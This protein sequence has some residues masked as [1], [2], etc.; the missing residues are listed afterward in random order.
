MSS[1]FQTV[2]A[3]RHAHSKPHATYFIIDIA[4]H[5]G[6]CTHLEHEQHAEL[7]FA[8]SNLV[9]LQIF[10]TYMRYMWCDRLLSVL[11]Y[12]NCILFKVRN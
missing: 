5:S 6:N 7:H 12:I 3:L 8:L 2:S 1:C 4:H 11:Y 10:G 9:E